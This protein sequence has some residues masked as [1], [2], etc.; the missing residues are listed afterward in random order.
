MTGGFAQYLVSVFTMIAIYSIAALG[1]NLQFGVAGL[2]NVGCAAF[3]AIGAYTSAIVTGPV[4]TH[5]LGGF[6][7]ALPFGLAAAATVSGMLALVVAVIVLRLDGDYLAIA[8]FGLAAAVQIAAINLG[9]LTGGP[10]GLSG[11]PLRLGESW[12]SSAWLAVC[13]T[14]AA[15]TFLALRHLDRST[16][17]RDMRAV[18]EDPEAAAAAGKHAAA[19]RLEAFVIG[20]ALMGLSGALY[21]HTT[22]FISPQDF[23]PIL[24]FQLYAMVIVGGTGRHVS[25]ILGTAVVWLIWSTSGQLFAATLPLWAQSSSGAIRVIAIAAALLLTLLLRPTGL[26]PERIGRR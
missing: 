17:G 20:A 21:A 18:S 9:G 15:L 25:A 2:F 22:G 16:W 23:L 8:S 1:L 12:P 24:T 19:F 10:G 7:Q 26:L 13:A 4:F 5:G 11:I 14:L 6:G 3:V